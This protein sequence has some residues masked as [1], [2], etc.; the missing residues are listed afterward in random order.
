[1]KKQRKAKPNDPDYIDIFAEDDDVDS[2]VPVDSLFD[3]EDSEP[4][5]GAS[6]KSDR[7]SGS[8]FSR[9][10]KAEKDHRS[11]DEDTEAVAAPRRNKKKRGL[12]SRHKDEADDNEETFEDDEED[13]DEEDFDEDFDEDELDDDEEEKGG[14]SSLISW[15]ERD[16]DEE[17]PAVRAPEPEPEQEEPERK[18][19]FSLSSLFK[20][21]NKEEESSEDKLLGAEDTE[22]NDPSEDHGSVAGKKH[23]PVYVVTASN[24]DED[25]D[26]GGDFSDPFAEPETGTAPEPEDTEETEE[27]A[28]LDPSDTDKARSFSFDRYGRRKEKIGRTHYGRRKNAKKATTTVVTNETDTRREE[29]EARLRAEKRDVIRDREIKKRKEER[30]V[31]VLREL[32]QRL[33]VAGLLGILLVLVLFAAYFAFRITGIDV[34]GVCSRYSSEQIVEMSGLKRGR[35]ILFQDMSGAREQLN[36]DPYLNASVKYVFP[37]KINITVSQRRGIGVVQWGPDSEYLALIDADGNVLEVDMASAGG[38]LVVK[39]LVV[40]RVVAGTKIGDE[41]DEQVQSTLDVLCALDEAGLLNSIS[42]IDMSETMG[43]SMYTPEGYRIELGNVSDLTTKLSRLKRGWKAIMSTAA[44][45]M[46]KPSVD[47]VTIY[48]Y[49]KSGVVVSPHDI[50]FVDESQTPEVTV[51]SAT[52]APGDVYEPEQEMVYATPEPTPEPEDII[53]SF[54]DEPFTG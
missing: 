24:A 12:F 39:G 30:R 42:S 49:A 51:I 40:T 8:L 5:S 53:P 27:E 52:P 36:A 38:L 32:K 23:T 16:E 18:K 21:A 35:H 3:D 34:T 11:E 43:I 41:A 28:E 48:L 25:W 14:L 22:E 17:P 10:K 20:T 26:I 31:R 7:S 46:K 15:R 45:Q 13:L 2:T 50:G 33:T 6:K 4:V 19:R 29:E 1:M 54:V 37:N 9:K 47:N 44:E